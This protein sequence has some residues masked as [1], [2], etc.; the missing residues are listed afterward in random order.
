MGKLKEKD[1][2]RG[3]IKVESKIRYKMLNFINDIELKPIIISQN[4][5]VSNH[6]E[7]A[8]LI[9]QNLIEPSFRKST[10][11]LFL[12]L[13]GFILLLNPIF[14]IFSLGFELIALA[15]SINSRRTELPNWRRRIAVAISILYIIL[16]IISLVILIMNPDLIDQMIADLQAQ[17][18]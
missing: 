16:F 17:G 1:L 15:L 7:R 8:N 14:G 4:A 18:Y 9:N 5:G 10:I 2:N 12:S 13:L 3:K 6:I 11:A